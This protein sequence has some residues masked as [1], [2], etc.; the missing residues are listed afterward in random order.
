MNATGK[1]PA[2]QLICLR[3]P[4][5]FGIALMLSARIAV[6]EP[7]SESL[8][9]Q[10]GVAAAHAA[11]AAASAAPDSASAAPDSVSAAHAAAESAHAP[12]PPGRSL[13]AQGRWATVPHDPGLQRAI[14]EAGLGN[15]AVQFDGMEETLASMGRVQIDQL[16]GREAL[17]GQ[18][19]AYTYLSMV[20]EAEAWAGAEIFP[21][22][23]PAVAAD[24]EA[25][26][27]KKWVS[28]SEAAHSAGA[29]NL[30]RK[31]DEF[32]NRQEQMGGLSL[33]VAAAVKAR[34]T[35]AKG[36]ALDAL[37]PEGFPPEG[38]RMLV[39]NDKALQAHQERLARVR[40]EIKES[41]PVARTARRLLERIHSLAALRETFR[42]APNPNQPDREWSAPWDPAIEPLPWGPAARE[43]DAALARAFRTHSPE[44]I[45]EAA[46]KFQEAAARAG[47]DEASGRRL[48]PAQWRCSLMTFY[49]QRKPFRIAALFY[50]L[51]VAAWAAGGILGES[52]GAHRARRAAVWILALA[53]G[54]HTGAEVLRLALSGRM[55]V[56]NMYESVTFTAWAAAAFG[57][58]FAW[59]KREI[60]YAA[61]AGGWGFLALGLVNF[62]PLHDTRIRPLRAVLQSYWL[63]LH[64][65]AMLLSYGCFLLAAFFAVSYLARS[66]GKSAEAN[67]PE[68][69][70]FE[71]LE[72]A[73][74]QCVL[75]GWPLLTIGIFLGGVWAQ[76]AWGRF[77]GWDPKETWALITWVIYTGYLHSRLALGW[78]GRISAVACLIGFLCVLLTWL[79]VS[80]LPGLAGGLH[81]YA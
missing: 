50:I 56:A 9:P 15:L 16:T 43:L 39:Q 64:V 69:R 48:Y 66:W 7:T 4:G 46:A 54:I 24:L 44:G 30:M 60:A 1:M 65:S 55:P 14:L 80:Y 68:R 72:T 53:F 23:H 3:F 28:A 5:L 38:F 75:A 41:A 76:T 22:G 59:R 61:A 77:W 36:E 47:N 70:G 19:P 11:H 29:M 40:E 25:A 2:S 52:R 33:I 42:I 74:Y 6:C 32:E 17:R 45:R 18:H 67:S 63:N 12:L 71:W 79:G 73:A 35:G 10:S 57:L 21:L 49:A 31:V 37:A 51:G 13:G 34:K 78:R 62:M 26:P 58:G 20:Y 27:G 81:S 8:A